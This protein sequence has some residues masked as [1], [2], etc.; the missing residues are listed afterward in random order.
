MGGSEEGWAG[1]S[2][3]EGREV[4]HLGLGKPESLRLVAGCLGSLN[5]KGASPDV[6][7]WGLRYE[8]RVG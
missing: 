1:R 3:Q 2:D 5:L 7:G 8:E 6:K 4:A